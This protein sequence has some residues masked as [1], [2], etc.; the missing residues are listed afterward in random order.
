MRQAE[1][2]VWVERFRSDVLA[3]V[4][5]ILR[6]ILECSEEEEEATPRPSVYV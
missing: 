2:Y 3:I 5:P 1:V 6:H 4:K